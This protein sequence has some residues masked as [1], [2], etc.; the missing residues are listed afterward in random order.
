MWLHALAYRKYRIRGAMFYLGQKAAADAL[1]GVAPLEPAAP[2]LEQPRVRQPRERPGQG[3]LGALPTTG[4]LSGRSGS[5][6]YFLTVGSETP[7]SRA[8]EAMLA[9]PLP[10]LL[11]SSILSTP[12]I[13]FLASIRRNRIN[14]NGRP[15][16][17]VGAPA[18]RPETF[19]RSFP[20]LRRAQID[21]AKAIKHTRASPSPS[22]KGSPRRSRASP[23]RPKTVGES[24]PTTAS[25]K[26]TAR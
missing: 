23:S 10:S 14:D 11:I 5:L 3:R 8:M 6:R 9:P 19:S 25:S 17:I 21:K 1:R 7:V 22:D 13:Y 4:G 15:N 18:L 24:A 20:K 26:S 2:V 12:I 16:G